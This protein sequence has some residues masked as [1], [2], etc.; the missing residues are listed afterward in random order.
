MNLALSRRSFVAG[1]GGALLFPT[2]GTDAVASSTETYPH[3]IGD[4]VVNIKVLQKG[5]GHIFVSLHDNENTGTDVASAM[6]NTYGG[7]L[8]ELAHSGERYISFKHQGVG[9]KFDPNRMF[10]DKGIEDTLRA[11]GD[12]SPEAHALVKSFAEVFL[13]KFKPGLVI[14]MH[15]NT[16]GNFAVTSYQAGG[17]MENEASDV[18]INPDIDP[19]NFFFVTSH[20]LFE[21]LKKRN[22]S[23]VLQSTGAVD[24]GSFSV[25]AASRGI[26]YVN[27]EAQDGHEA[28]QRAMVEALM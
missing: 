5:R 6:V 16:N 11:Q 26:S 13:E 14:A 12:Y 25:Y 7:R 9:Y 17:D 24:D 19:D 23:V 1:L 15:N 21:H 8:L 22:F 20:E 10:S 18:Y 2:F 28:F 3:L 4:R 27:V